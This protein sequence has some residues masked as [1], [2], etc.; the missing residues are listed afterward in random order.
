MVCKALI[1]NEL[2][3]AKHKGRQQQV[4]TQLQTEEWLTSKYC[5][6]VHNKSRLPSVVSI[7]IILGVNHTS[8]SEC[9]DNK[10]ISD[11]L[12]TGHLTCSLHFIITFQLCH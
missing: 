10:A 3:R 8:G 6:G 5:K 2:R 9:I 7:V 11:Y 12:V 4:E 1:L